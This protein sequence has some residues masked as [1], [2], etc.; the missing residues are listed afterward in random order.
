MFYRWMFAV[1]CIAVVS[2]LFEEEYNNAD[3]VEGETEGYIDFEETNR[4]IE[5]VILAPLQ[6]INKEVIP[7]NNVS[8]SLEVTMD[9]SLTSVTNFDEISGEINIVAFLRLSWNAVNLPRWKKELLGGRT[10]LTISS[11]SIWTP[12]VF[13]LNPA[14]TVKDLT[15]VSQNL[16]I[17]NNGTVSWELIT[18]VEVS[19][20]SFISVL[21]TFQ[22]VEKQ[23]KIKFYN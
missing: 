5:Q 21:H 16:R 8:D 4:R 1:S 11:D 17:S 18:G 20:E 15:A 12:R 3:Y 9:F 7:L 10:S 22:S 13:V 6:K 2:S 19:I 23:C 14:K